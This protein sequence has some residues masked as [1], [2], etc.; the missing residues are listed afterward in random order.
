[1]PARPRARRERVSRSFASSEKKTN[2][3][4]LVRRAAHAALLSFEKNPIAADQLVERFSSADFDPRDRAFLRELIYGVLRWRN[5]LDFVFGHFLNKP[6]VAP[7]VREALRLGTYQLLFMDRVPPH[8]AVDGSVSLVNRRN[9]NWA[10]GLVNAVLRKVAE[11]EV[12]PPENREDYLTI[13][14]SHPGWL[15][16]RWMRE[17][18]EEEAQGRCRAN[19]AEAPV[20]FR[21]NTRVSNAQS[22]IAELKIE[23]VATLPGCAD[24]D[25]LIFFPGESTPGVRFSDTAAWREGKFI[26]MD[27]GSSLVSRFAGAAAGEKIL[28]VCAAPGGKTACLAWAAGVSGSVVA[29]DEASHRLAR[30]K[31]NCARIRANV[32]ILRMDGA[33]PPF[34]EKFDLVL[35]DAPCSGLGVFRRHPDA[36]WRLREEDLAAQARRQMAI[37][38]GAAGAV[39]RGGRLVYSVCTNETEETEEVASSFRE[40]GFVPI[41]DGGALPGSARGFLGPDGALRITPGTGL[42]G[43]FAMSWRKEGG[44]C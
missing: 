21:V 4:H 1:M 20:V 44:N 25:C 14:E 3:S 18:G 10:K 16:R 19:N 34:H 43:F 32:P 27:E 35:V 5:R 22:L 30:L 9:L 33:R 6:N 36:R 23:G 42:D 31:G 41:R 24:P 26:V 40:P 38:R 39:R 37:L 11:H 28:D 15:V 17:L 7:P 29:G 13:W 2:S 8:G 12:S